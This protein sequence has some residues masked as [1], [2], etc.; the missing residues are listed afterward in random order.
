MTEEHLT[1]VLEAAVQVMQTTVTL[2]ETDVSLQL[3]LDFLLSLLF[4]LFF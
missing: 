4:V 3:H 2:D 1:H